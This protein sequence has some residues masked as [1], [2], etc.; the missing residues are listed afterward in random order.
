MSDKFKLNSVLLLSFLLLALFAFW[1][2]NPSTNSDELPDLLPMVNIEI[3]LEG[4]TGLVLNTDW[5]G[6]GADDLVTLSGKHIGIYTLHA[7]DLELRQ[8]ARVESDETAEAFAAVSLD[9]DADGDIDLLVLHSYGIARY[10]NRDNRMWPKVI[11]NLDIEQ[12]WMAASDFD[13]DGVLD[14]A[15]SSVNGNERRTAIYGLDGSEKQLIAHHAG[16]IAWADFDNNRS[17]DLVLAAPDQP[18]S[19]YSSVSSQ[20]TALQLETGSAKWSSI[21]TA[22]LDADGD[23]DLLLSNNAYSARWRLLENKSQKNA[24]NLI[25]VDAGVLGKLRFATQA[26]FEDINADGLIDVLA[27]Q[28][29]P[30]SLPAGCCEGVAMLQNLKHVESNDGA[31]AV[32]QRSFN[33]AAAWS[34]LLSNASSVATGDYNGDGLVDLA[35]YAVGGS[36]KVSLNQRDQ[37]YVAVRLPQTVSS[38][39]ARV[40]VQTAGGT[41]YTEQMN[42]YGDLHFGLGPNWKSRNLVVR[43][44]NGAL[45]IVEQP[46]INQRLYITP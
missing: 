36:L 15:V 27:A 6:D 38:L 16:P 39:G 35:A 26:V 1:P 8:I 46:H 2:L 25:P 45:T 3:P 14:L 21:S 17:D 30:T 4:N 40:T 41:S 22:D 23:Q 24:L 43:W 9:W 37:N 28:Q 29:P 34:G 32:V 18:V 19:I 7:A 10:E 44:P 11:A 42:G 13:R 12:G 33:N 31:E 5:N 20:W